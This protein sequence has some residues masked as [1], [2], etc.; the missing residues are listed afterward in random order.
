MTSTDDNAGIKAPLISVIIPSY[1]HA[2]YLREAIRSVQSQHYP[3]VEII[4]V[5]DGSTDNTAAVVRE[6]AGVNYIRQENMGLSGARN[7]GWRASRGEFVVFLDADDCLLP[8]A[9]EVG[10]RELCRRPDCAFVSGR[11]RYINHDGTLLNS[12]HGMIMTTDHYQALL[13]GNYIGMH[14]TVMYRREILA[15]MGGFDVTLPA[16]EDYDLYLRIARLQPVARHDWQV[17]DYR[18]HQENMS[19]NPALMLK[20]VLHVMQRQKPHVRKNPGYQDAYDSGL[21]AWRKYYGG[22]LLLRLRQFIKKWQL[23]EWVA[24]MKV[25]IRH[26]PGFTL[27]YYSRALLNGGLKLILKGMGPLLPLFLRRSIHRCLGWDFNAKVGR[28]DWGDLRRL[29]PLCREFGFSRGQP[30]DRYYIENFLAS[31]THDIRGRVMEVGDDGYTRQWGG[32]RVTTRD[33]LHV[34]AGNPQATIIGSL[35]DLDHVEDNRFDCIILTQ[36]LQFIFDVKAAI[37]TIH[38][39]LKPGGVLLATVPGISQ[40]SIDEWGESWYWSFTKNSI[41]PLFREWFD[42]THLVIDSY[43]NVMA[44]TAFLNGLAAEELSADELNYDDAQYQLLITIR[45]VKNHA[46]DFT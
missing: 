17:A 25:L 5:D 10:A 16:C 34:K 39:L 42:E 37:K 22:L 8:A 9:L 36:T 26:A 40:I 7:T 20:T 2:H 45:A 29:N 15:T 21:R 46:D 3:G 18:Q 6:S 14:A 35:T 1:N 11:Y 19:G 44:S 32:D 31:H 33:I 24:G 30:I 13:Q 4:V 43:G 38:R 41:Q 23:K 27:L 28:V 12:Y